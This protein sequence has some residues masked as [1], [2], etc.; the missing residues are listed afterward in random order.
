M[1]MSCVTPGETIDPAPLARV[2]E[3]ESLAY[4]LFLHWGLYSLLGAGE[5]AVE[6]RSIPW[7]QYQA[8]RSQFTA[9]E[10]NPRELVRFARRVGFRY[11]CL[12]TRHHDGFSLYDTRGL[13]DWDAPHS[14]AGRDLVAEFADACHAAGM[15][16]FFYHTLLDWRHPAFDGR[17]PADWDEYLEYLNASVEVLAANYGPV[18][19]F[20][21]DG[22]WAR[23]DRDWK[24][25]ALYAVC[26]RHQPECVIVNN[27]GTHARGKVGHPD[28]DVATFEQGRPKRLRRTRRDR[29]VA[30]EMSETINSHWGVT[31]RDF[32][33]K[34]PA[35]IIHTLAC[36]RRHGANLLLNV[37][38]TAGGSLPAYEAA[39]LEIVGRWVA[40]CG[41]RWLYA[42]RPTEL[43]ARGP[44]FVLRDGGDY[45][46]FLHHLPI[47]DAAHTPH[48]ANGE[49]G[50]GLRTVGGLRVPVRDI[51][52]TDNNERLTFSQDVNKG[53]LTFHATEHHYGEQYVVR[54]ARIAT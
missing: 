41:G 22:K 45:Y 19:G 23:K 12:T 54:V 29:Y 13:S 18:A 25:D 43:Q 9:S 2:R 33:Y 39:L 4:G 49:S 38:P 52:W 5:W 40:T 37:G 21:F 20:W 3:F 15:K 46:Y 7:E 24:E 8:L 6:H 1:S 53:M 26:R 30:A 17:N 28:V 35:D 14:A 50:S 42:A 36:C 48:V 44:D 10:W 51:R 31:A 34:S 11:V 16:M 27:S 47:R 32:S